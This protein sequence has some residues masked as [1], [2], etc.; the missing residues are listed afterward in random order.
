MKSLT[1]RKI[2]PAVRL[3]LEAAQT[4]SE[5]LKWARRHEAPR[6]VFRGQSHGWPLKPTAGRA[7]TYS[8]VREVQLFNEF[9]RLASPFVD[10]S[11]LTTDWDWLFVAQHH[12]LPTRLL[13]WTLN[14]LVA[15]Y[16]ACQPNGRSRRPGVLTAV[17]VNGVG[18]VD[19]IGSPFEISA[20]GFVYPTAVAARISSQRGLFSVHPE[21]SKNWVLR[22]K[23]E[24][25]EIPVTHKE[26]I[27]SFLF[28]VGVDAAMVMADLDGLASNLHWRYRN[29]HAI[30]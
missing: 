6:F 25:F 19:P 13:D 22:G 15:A 21:P 27:L 5:L 11:A 24:Q 14:P 23:R 7:K 29:G 16:F 17:E 4:W 3:R 2:P 18:L 12:G 10:R 20:P 8:T 28:G 30:Q 1:V 26:F 9:K